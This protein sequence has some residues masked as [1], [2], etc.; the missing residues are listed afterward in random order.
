[1]VEYSI[2]LDVKSVCF[3]GSLLIPAV[4]SA[5]YNSPSSRIVDVPEHA[6]DMRKPSTRIHPIARKTQDLQKVSQSVLR[7]ANICGVFCV[8]GNGGQ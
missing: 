6:R 3:F 5:E 4:C 1:M 8:F 2:L 7:S